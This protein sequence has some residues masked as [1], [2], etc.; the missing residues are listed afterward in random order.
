[1]VEE[2]KLNLEAL[3]KV[4]RNNTITPGT[5]GFHTRKRS[6]FQYEK[7]N[8]ENRSFKGDSEMGDARSNRRSGSAIASNEYINTEHQPI[9]GNYLNANF[10][11]AGNNMGPPMG[12]RSGSECPG[13]SSRVSSV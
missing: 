8:H 13:T 7:K 6:R 2:V 12:L 5:Q 1:M 3:R 10:A 11:S 4:T 9:T